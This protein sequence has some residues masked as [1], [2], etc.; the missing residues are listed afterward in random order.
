MS[1]AVR[2]AAYLVA[3]AVLA[4]LAAVGVIT[5]DQA[6]QFTGHL[7]QALDLATAIL[8]LVAARHVPDAPDAERP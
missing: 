6:D 8:L 1:P 5:P 4:V 7:D 2:R 3:A